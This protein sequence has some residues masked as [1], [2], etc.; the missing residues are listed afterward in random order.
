MNKITV[1]KPKK[2]I[3]LNFR[4]IFNYRALLWILAL[5]DIKVKYKQTIIGGLWAIFQPLLTMIILNI[6]FGEM[7]K[8]YSRDIPYPVFL[9]SG[10]ILWIYFSNSI[11]NASNS[12]ISNASLISKTYCPKIIIPLSTTLPGLLDYFI[13]SFI[14]LGMMIYFNFF[15]K[16][17]IIFIPLVLFFTWIL[18]S[19][20]GFWLSAMNVKYRD[21]KYILPFFIQLLIFVTPVIYP[22]SGA[23]RFKWLLVMNPMTGLIEAH[24]SMILG[25]TVNLEILSISVLITIIVFLSGM[26]YF[27]STEKYF[28]D[29]I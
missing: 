5:R 16:I 6:F 7:A 3:N 2:G 26:A 9:Y 13:A 4:E 14:I 18:S 24:R 22:F 11:T 21:V 17:P 27:K 20:V 10:L 1:I 12:L 15:P 23:G 19:G 25:Q 28:A 8:L 29:I